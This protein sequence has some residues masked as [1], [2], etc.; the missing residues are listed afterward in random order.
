MDEQRQDDQLKPIYNSSV[1]IHGVALKT[2][3]KGGRIG[4]GRSTLVAQHDDIYIYIENNIST[5]ITT[6]TI[7]TMNINIYLYMYSYQSLS[8]SL[9]IYI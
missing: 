8:L 6:T 7:I 9:S 2:I 1:P 4:S 5:I 3:E